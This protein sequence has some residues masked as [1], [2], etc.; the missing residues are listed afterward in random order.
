MLGDAEQ[1]CHLIKCARLTSFIKYINDI[2][3][4]KRSVS[5]SLLAINLPFLGSKNIFHLKLTLTYSISEKGKEEYVQIVKMMLSMD[6][7][8]LY[9]SHGIF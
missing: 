7:L 9:Q 2:Y 3:M 1:T 8:R 4:Y 5:R 6:W